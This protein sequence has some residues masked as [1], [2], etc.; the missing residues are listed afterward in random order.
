MEVSTS[1]IIIDP[2]SACVC[3]LGAVLLVMDIR[4]PLSLAP[5]LAGIASS[6]ILW[7]VQIY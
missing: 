4:H 6:A 1:R 3:V 7:T 2:R 5:I